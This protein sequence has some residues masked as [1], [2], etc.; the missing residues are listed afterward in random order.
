MLQHRPHEEAARSLWQTL[1]ADNPVYQHEKRNLPGRTRKA[2]R[3][4]RWALRLLSLPAY[5]GLIYL[6]Y[7][8]GALP[9]AHA[10]HIAALGIYSGLMGLVSVALCIGLEGATYAIS[11]EREKRT[12]EALLL[13]RL[14]PQQILLGK[15]LP[16]YEGLLEIV[17]WLAPAI[18]LCGVL[19][20]VP[21][22][23]FLL[24]A[25]VAAVTAALSV[26]RM[27]R[28][29]LL[30]G[31]A[32]AQGRSVLA[33]IPGLIILS[34]AFTGIAYTVAALV[35]SSHG[36]LTDLLRLSPWMHYAAFAPNLLSPMAA[37][38]LTLPVWDEV[39]VVPLALRLGVVALYLGVAGW[40]TRALW[41]KTLAQF[42]DAAKD[43]PPPPP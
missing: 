33:K 24:T 10:R 18:L 25:A 30:H 17:A 36:D 3:F 32:K 15:L 40:F 1:V 35:A 21:L 31:V 2:A 12:W 4:E 22:G 27:A 5:Y 42:W 8:S 26:A 9:D 20:G 38:A 11:R 13:T 6:F 23:S 34:P 16:R 28:I 41:R 43:S 7:L 37:F 39:P 29:M 14:T 19:G